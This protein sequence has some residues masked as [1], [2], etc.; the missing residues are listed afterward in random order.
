MTRIM[1]VCDFLFYNEYRLCRPPAPSHAAKASLVRRRK[2]IMSELRPSWRTPVRIYECDSLGHVNNAVYVL[3]LQQATLET[4][5]QAATWSLRQLSVEYV[6]QAFYG[7]SLQVYAW[8]WEPPSAQGLR[9]GYAIQRVGDDAI[10]AR[11]EAVWAPAGDGQ[12]A[13]ALGGEW[14]AV[15]PPAALAIK[16]ARPLTGQPAARTFHWQS[17]V[18]GYEVCSDGQVRPAEFLRW[19]EDARMAAAGEVGWTPARLR[20]AG[21]VIVQTRHDSRFLGS[22]RAGDQVLIHSR[23]VEMRRVRGVWRHEIYCGEQLVAVDHSNGAFLD[24][25]GHPTPAPQAMVD[26][27]LGKNKT[28]SV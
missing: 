11:G 19:V 6:A 12:A 2:T 5:P 26:A 1:A 10:I 23:I 21:R 17:I 9:C 24:L 16:Q 7:D 8:P 15:E 20:A 28:F 27:L 14:S 25:D 4:W 3:Y 22:L 13:A 18:R